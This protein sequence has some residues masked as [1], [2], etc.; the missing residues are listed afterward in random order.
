MR[1]NLDLVVKPLFEEVCRSLT[2]RKKGKY[3]LHDFDKT[4]LYLH[5][6]KYTFA[7]AYDLD[8]GLDFQEYSPSYPQRRD[9]DECAL[10]AP[11]GSFC[12][13]SIAVE[14]RMAAYDDTKAMSQDFRRLVFTRDVLSAMEYYSEFAVGLVSVTPERVLLPT[15]AGQGLPPGRPLI[16]RDLRHHLFGNRYGPNKELFPDLD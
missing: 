1:Q 14:D 2:F 13:K 4:R 10:G 15:D 6:R 16:S 9:L 12:D 7:S 8:S 5:L 11:L 3:W